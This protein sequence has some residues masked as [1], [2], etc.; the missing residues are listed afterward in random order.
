MALSLP[1]VA[2]ATLEDGLGVEACFETGLAAAVPELEPATADFWEG[3]LAVE[4]VALAFE[5]EA[6]VFGLVECSALALV[7]DLSPEA[8]LSAFGLV[9]CAVFALVADLS[10]EAILSAAGLVECS[11][12]TL[13]ADVGAFAD[14]LDLLPDLAAVSPEA[15]VLGFFSLVPA[16]L[17]LVVPA[18]IFEGAFSDVALLP[19]VDFAGFAACVVLEPVP[20]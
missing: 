15:V 1:A 2:F 6:L 12:L 8:I 17:F 7:A 3:A 18:F 5:A 14:L 11:V 13:V 20:V 4:P 16:V 10:P 9:E 19:V